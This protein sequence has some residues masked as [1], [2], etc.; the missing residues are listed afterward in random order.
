MKHKLKPC[1]FCGEKDQLEV[2]NN[3]T[4]CI[5]HGDYVKV[6]YIVCHKCHSTGPTF[7]DWDYPHGDRKTMAIATWN[8]RARED[9]HGKEE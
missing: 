8:A 6:S 3:K 9:S 2:I 5:G 7:D 1:P 4:H